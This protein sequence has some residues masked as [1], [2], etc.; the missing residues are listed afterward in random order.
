MQELIDHLNSLPNTA[1]SEQGG[2][3][4]ISIVKSTPLE[5]KLTVAWSV[6]EWSVDAVAS[7]ETV[8][9][10]WVDYYPIDGES[11]EELRANMSEDFK[12]FVTKLASREVR[13]VNRMIPSGRSSDV[14]WL[15]GGH[16]L[17]VSIAEGI[18]H[19]K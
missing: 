4:T 13:I 8:W 11:T 10:D 9:S 12:Q 5:F 7:H 14:Q 1:V 19:D 17:S 3:W 16:W 18:E 15:D 6:L 2:V